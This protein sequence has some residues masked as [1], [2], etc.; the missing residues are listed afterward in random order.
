MPRIYSYI[1]PVDDGAAPNPFGGICTL[2]ICKPAIRRNATAGCWVIGT[3][4][5]HTRFRDGLF[6]DLSKTLVYAMKVTDRKSLA[7]YDVFCK[8][9]LTIKIPDW[10]SKRFAKRVGDCLYD[11]SGGTPPL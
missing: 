7:D 8:A 5:K 11:Y 2:T 10:N 1:I 6:Y 9:Q 3:G 4:S